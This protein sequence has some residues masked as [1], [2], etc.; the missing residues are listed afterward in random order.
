MT[1]CSVLSRASLYQQP[2]A[3]GSGSITEKTV[4][5]AMGR[6]PTGH[7]YGPT[8]MHTL[9]SLGYNK[10]MSLGKGHFGSG[11]KENW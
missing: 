1:R 4:D 10:D 5:A 8:L 11:S 7:T 9:V 6:L 2:I 3:Q